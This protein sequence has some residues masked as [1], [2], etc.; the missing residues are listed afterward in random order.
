MEKRILYFVYFVVITATIILLLEFID[1]FQFQGNLSW[2]G[3]ELF[4]K[5]Q[6]SD[7][8]FVEVINEWWSWIIKGVSVLFLLVML[9]TRKRK[10]NDNNNAEK[11]DSDNIDTDF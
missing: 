1:S 6:S 9:F 7:W 3:H 5:S 11:N 10:T 8:A 2:G 4:S